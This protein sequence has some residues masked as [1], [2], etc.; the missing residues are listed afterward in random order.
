MS[1]TSL[2]IFCGVLFVMDSILLCLAVYLAGQRLNYLS[3]IEDLRIKI[4]DIGFDKQDAEIEIADLKEKLAL[5]GVNPDIDLNYEPSEYMDM[6][7]A[8]ISFL[9]HQGYHF[10]GK[11]RSLYDLKAG[12]NK[13][14]MVMASSSTMYVFEDGCWVAYPY[15]SFITI[16]ENNK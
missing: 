15:K 11:A 16:K 9:E 2:S 14:F 13:D 6:N 1:Y 10:K 12:V 5:N 7:S 8:L 4:Q 3:Q